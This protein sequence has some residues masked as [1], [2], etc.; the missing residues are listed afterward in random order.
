MIDFT[1]GVLDIIQDPMSRGIGAGIKQEKS[2][3][4]TQPTKTTAP[5]KEKIQTKKNTVQAVVKNSKTTEVPADIQDILNSSAPAQRLDQ[6]IFGN[7]K[8]YVS[9]LVNEMLDATVSKKLQDEI[10]AGKLSLKTSEL[11]KTYATAVSY[12]KKL[13]DGS[14]I[15][16]ELRNKTEKKISDLINKRINNKIFSWQKNLGDFGKILLS[17]SKLA[18]SLRAT[19]NKEVHTAITSLVSDKM[20]SGINDA[21]LGN[22]KKISDTIKTTI[23]TQFKSQIENFV[24]LR[25][26]VQEKI[27]AFM[28]LKKEYEKKI[29]D[30]IKSLTSKIGE[31]VK[32]FTKKM[33][34]SLSNSVKSLVS[35]KKLA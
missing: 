7:D 10:K 2:V 33:V 30:A 23:N 11:G 31:A 14:L 3:T 5:A 4:K 1:A 34:D 27:V 13:Y 12:Y 29:A 6:A 24:K 21:L 15:M 26:V 16:T 28:E 35:G 20:I 17:K 25:S 32:Q 8:N 22:L 9:K 19:I 18:S